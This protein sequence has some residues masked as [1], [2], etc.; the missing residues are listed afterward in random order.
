MSKRDEWTDEST[1]EIDVH[2]L[3]LSMEQ[4]PPLLEMVSGP[5]A[6]RTLEIFADAMVLGRALDAEIPIS[7]S[8]LSRRH[9]V[10]TRV[11]PQVTLTD[12]GSR[13]GVYLNGVKVHAAVLHEGDNI[14]LGTVM[15]VFHEGRGGVL[16]DDGTGSAAIPVNPL[17]SRDVGLVAELPTPASP[18]PMR[19]APKRAPKGRGN[20]R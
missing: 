4:R 18:A 7:A 10:L 8:D 16:P 19:P 6:P 11:G 14:Q 17:P 12:L 9:L 3:P 2:L 15:F 20:K 13:N 5:G 1:N